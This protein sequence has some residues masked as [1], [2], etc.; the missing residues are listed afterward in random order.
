MRAILSTLLL[1][2]PVLPPMPH[3]TTASMWPSTP[4]ASGRERTT[5]P[6][7]VPAR[8]SPC[9]L[10]WIPAST[11]ILPAGYT[12]TVM[13]MGQATGTVVV[14][15][16]GTISCVHPCHTATATLPTTGFSRPHCP[17][18][19]QQTV[20]SPSSVGAPLP[21]AAMRSTKCAYRP[22]ALLIL[23]PVP[24]LFTPKADKATG[25]SAPC[26]S[27]SMPDRPSA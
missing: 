15:T 17:S 22:R 21:T 8:P 12:R 16:R 5:T 18:L 10:G 3:T 6:L 7:S 9:S 4:C 26:G 11:T 20:L 2:L 24:T 23:P 13:I 14:P 27:T 25:V 19:V 1:S